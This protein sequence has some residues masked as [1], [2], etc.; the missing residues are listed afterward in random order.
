M[1][2]FAL[3]AALTAGQGF[4]GISADSGYFGQVVTQ[5]INPENQ[6]LEI[7]GSTSFPGA[8]FFFP[9]PFDA[10]A[11]LASEIDSYGLYAV[12]SYPYIFLGN[13]TAA[14]W[15]AGGYWPDGG[16]G[17]IMEASSSGTLNFGYSDLGINSPNFDC[18]LYAFPSG[19]PHQ[20]AYW[21]CYST[22]TNLGYAQTEVVD[23]GFFGVSNA[24]QYCLNGTCLTSWPGAGGC[25]YSGGVMYCPETQFDAGIMVVSGAQVGLDITNTSSVYEDVSGDI[26]LKATPS[27]I[28]KL[29]TTGELA[30]A[31]VDAGAE[32]Y[33][34]KYCIS[35]NGCITSWPSGGL[36]NPYLGTFIADAGD[37]ATIQVPVLANLP[38]ITVNNIYSGANVQYYTDDGGKTVW[39]VTGG[40]GTTP[41]SITT[42]YGLQFNDLFTYA[43]GQLIAQAVDAGSEMYAFD[44]N[45]STLE[46]SGQY[47]GVNI[48]LPHF[49][50]DIAAYKTIIGE[51]LIV[52]GGPIWTNGVIVGSLD[53]GTLPI[54]TGNGLVPSLSTFDGGSSFTASPKISGG[55]IPLASANTSYTVTFS[56]SGDSTRNFTVAPIC[57]CSIVDN[58]INTAWVSTCST[59]TT[60]ITV[61]NGGSSP[62]IINYIC[63][64]Y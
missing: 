19:N 3:I 30:A 10:G 8:N 59:S 27:G 57:N 33:A 49:Q 25:Y 29:Q 13:N 37:F 61:Q 52:D 11:P 58:T 28:F 2:A 43:N 1:H 12:S 46:L 54:Y 24:A 48:L 23:A 35:G 32:A 53:A 5:N 26:V 21:W 47:T 22:S 18:V 64:G 56:G 42:G 41:T 20:G 62:T 63:V 38:D 4:P 45:A 6:Q 17:M 15:D 16:Y 9:F 51:P 14:M 31:V 36:S 40:S 34:A 44:M 60:G 50:T 39:N 55:S 7:N